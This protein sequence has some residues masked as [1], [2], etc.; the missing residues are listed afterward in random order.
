MTSLYERIGGDK[1]LHSVVDK[2]FELVLANE[3]F[4]EF[5]NKT[6]IPKEKEKQVQYLAKITGGPHKYEGKDMKEAHSNVKVGG[7]MFDASWTMM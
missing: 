3:K 4:S 2:F 5:F 7:E 1:V 6:D